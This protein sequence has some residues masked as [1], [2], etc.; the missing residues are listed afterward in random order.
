MCLYKYQ[1][2]RNLALKDMSKE[3]EFK[4][5]LGAFKD[6]EKVVKKIEDESILERM[7]EEILPQ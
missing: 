5:L 7:K 6:L 2:K 4:M 1:E 3:N